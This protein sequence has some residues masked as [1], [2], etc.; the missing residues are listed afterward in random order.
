M[1]VCQAD[2]DRRD[3]KTKKKSPQKAYFLGTTTL[4]VTI[5]WQSP[6]HNAIC[7]FVM[8]SRRTGKASSHDRTTLTV[9]SSPSQVPRDLL[10]LQPIDA[11]MMMEAVLPF[12]FRH[13]LR[14]VWKH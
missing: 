6:L 3:R 11:K 10:F 5:V 4:T 1:S 13:H 8:G 7:Q 12:G 14:I 2:F 9:N